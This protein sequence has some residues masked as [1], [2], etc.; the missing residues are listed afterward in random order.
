M[1]KSLLKSQRKGIL[2]L[3]KDAQVAYFKNHSHLNYV[4]SELILFNSVIV[5]FLIFQLELFLVAHK[6]TLH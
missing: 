2:N 4:F 3:S 6:L 5:Y 1:L